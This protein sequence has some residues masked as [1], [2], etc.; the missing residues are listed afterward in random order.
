MIKINDL[1]DGRFRIVSRIGTGGM[2]D[3]YEAMDI[4]SKKIVSLK[5]MK[6]ELLIDKANIIRFEEEARNLASLNHPN[7]IK[8]YGVGE[9]ENRPYM[10]NEYIKGSTLREKLKYNVTF[11][12]P[13]TIEIMLQ[14]T[15]GISYVHKRGII[16]RDIKPENLFL[17]ADGT[18][19]I[20][21]FGISLI[22][23]NTNST[24][25]VQG[26]IFYCAPETLLGKEASKSNDIYSMGVVFYELLTGEVPFEGSNKEEV[27]YK[28][29]KKKFP[30]VSKVRFDLPKELDKLILDAV[31]KDPEDRYQSA[32]EF[33]E[34]ILNFNKNKDNLNER[35]GFLSRV[36]GFK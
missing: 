36:F 5:V 14:L 35:K 10:A 27:A 3:I 34:A 8:I 2:A 21:D 31:A 23:G 30:E 16:H 6:E 33:Y 26:T 7:I 13:E 20:G 19:K 11:S 12:L 4:I 24:V 9:V 25:G 1:I 28:H 17:L 18:L 29:M 32:E 15:S 22:E